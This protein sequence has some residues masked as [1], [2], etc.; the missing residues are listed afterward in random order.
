MKKILKRAICLML[1]AALLCGVCFNGID[2]ISAAASEEESYTIKL[3]KQE[4]KQGVSSTHT[5]ADSQYNNCA[6]TEA[7]I[8]VHE[9]YAYVLSFEVPED[10]T[11]QIGKEAWG[12]SH[13]RFNNTDITGRKAE[14]C[15]T[16]QDG[17][18]LY[19]T[20]GKVVVLDENTT[21]HDITDTVVNVSA[22]D[23]IN[24]V[25]YS[26]SGVKNSFW[27]QPFSEY[28]SASYPNKYVTNWRL[29]PM[30][31]SFNDFTTLYYADDYQ[32]VAKSTPALS[33]KKILFTGDSIG[34]GWRDNDGVD[35]YSNSGGWAKRIADDYGADVTLAAQAGWA[36]STIRE[37]EGRG[38]IVNQLH[39]HKD[40]DFDYIVLEGGFNDAMG[41]NED[42]TKESAAPVGEMTDSFDVN[43]FN[44]AEFA[45]ALE[46]LFYY[47][48][49][50]Y[51]D[52]GI[53]FIITYA[54]PLST[55]GGYTAEV[56]SMR[57]YWNMAKAICNKWDIEYLDLFDGETAAGLSYSYDILKVDT[58]NNF[59]GGTDQIHLNAAGYDVITPYI[60]EWIIENMTGN[61]SEETLKW[62]S[63]LVTLDFEE[64]YLDE[65]D[66][67]YYSDNADNW[68]Y[69][70]GRGSH[71]EMTTG[72]DGNSAVRLTY[73]NQN[74]NENYN[75]NAVMNIYN[76]ETKSR[77]VGTAGTTYTIT[78]DYKVEETDGKELQLF[79][80]PSNRDMGY[81]NNGMHA[82]QQTDMGPGAVVSGKT[83]TFTEATDVITEK[84]DGWVTVSTKYT[85]QAAVNEHEVYP[86]ILLQTNNKTKDTTHTGNRD[87]AA[88]LIDNL[89]VS[90]K[91][92][93]VELDFEK[94]CLN[95][96]ETNYY[97]GGTNESSD[98]TRGS[99]A[100]I[101][102][103]DAGNKAMRL[104]YDNQNNNENYNANAAFN[105]Y[106]SSTKTKFVGTAGK[107]YIITFDYKVECTDD[108]EMQLYVATCG[109]EYLKYS[110]LKSTA[111]QAQD[112]KFIPATG[113]ITQT[114][115][116]YVTTTVSYTANGKDYPIILLST[117]NST[118]DETH[119]G[120][121]AYASVLVDNVKIQGNQ[122]AFITCVNYNGND[123]SL[124]IY[125]D[126]T[127]ADLTTPS[128]KGYIFDGW[129][130][131]ADLM[132]K[133]NE[134]ELVG[135]YKRIYVKWSGDGTAVV[136]NEITKY[137]TTSVGN[138]KSINT[139]TIDASYFDEEITYVQ[140]SLF[141]VAGST[142]VSNFYGSF[143]FS[144]KNVIENNG[145]KIVIKNFNVTNPTAD[146][147]V[148]YV[149]IPDYEKTG[150]DWGLGLGDQ[151]I[152]VSQ[153]GSVIYTNIDGGNN[154]F[155]YSM[156]NEW[157]DSTISANGVFTGLPAGY[158]GYI[159]INLSAL[160]YKNSVD[161]NSSYTFS[162]MELKMNALGGENGD[163]V[164]GGLFYFPNTISDSTV[165][166]IGGLYYELS[167][168]DNGI[169]VDS[170]D[171]YS[172]TG[173]SF[174]T[175]YT[176]TT[177]EPNVKHV[178]AETSA[179]WGTA[180]VG[181][182]TKSGNAETTTGY[183][184]TYINSETAIL[185]QPGV[186]SIMFYVEM[187]KYTAS[188]ANPGLKLLDFTLEQGNV[189]Q[190][191]NFFNSVY[192]Y[193]SVNDASWKV[194][195][196]GADGELYDIPSGFKGYI[197]VDVKQFKNVPEIKGEV[198]FSKP[199]YITKFELGFNHI[200]GENGNL[201]IGGVYSVIK[202][203]DVPFLKHGINGE[204]Y[205][206][207][208]IPGDFNCDGTYDAK[209]IGQIRNHLV[210]IDNSLAAPAK[211]RN[212]DVCVTTLVRA[213]KVDAGIAKTDISVGFSSV[214]NSDNIFTPNITSNNTPTVYRIE[215]VQEYSKKIEA[216]TE[217]N[218]D[219]K[220]IAFAKE[221][222]ENKV[223]DF[224]KTGID[225]MCHVS[226]FAYAKGNIYMSYYANAISAYEHPDYQVARLAYAPEDDTSKK[227][228]LD[229]MQVGDDICGR[230]VTG[231]YDTVLMQRED[232]PDNLYILWTARIN[233][234]YY[235]LYRIFNMET[236][237]LGKINVN[238]F[239]VGD[240]TND[241]SASGMQEAMEANNVGYKHFIEDI[242]IMQKLSTRVEN[243]KT[244][245]YA[246][247]YSG[248]FT[249]IIKST[250]LITWEYVAQPNEGANNTGFANATL[251]ENAVY[252]LDD[253]VYYFVRQ[254]DPNRMT[255]WGY[256][257]GYGYDKD[258]GSLYGI[259]TYYDLNTGE[260]AQPVL[261]GD[262]Q[263]RSDFIYY[264]G[265]LYLF[266]APTD[267]AHIGILKIDT[268]E[269]SKTEV[270]LQAQMLESCFYPFVQYNSTGELCM[271][272]T[273]DRQHIRLASFK[274]S[275]YLD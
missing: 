175:R 31:A 235:R 60:A 178:D 148:F 239:K 168:V 149:E 133:A 13:I 189:E 165:M 52:A 18:I 102:T 215:E 173:S 91:T 93:P 45:G 100:E 197:K 104:T 261:V 136:P 244:Y 56:E 126:T 144:S 205:C 61:V 160:N 143:V 79:I 16:N 51:P 2:I 203:S 39:S 194:A 131:D 9:G 81:P 12:S 140:N 270:V 250:D 230:K 246:G 112:V 225:K 130:T 23:T 21:Q 57:E 89:I 211:L 10:G 86:I 212:M 170:Y 40:T 251:W 222:A 190:T 183:M 74:S 254:W 3:T 48:K 146:A 128:R 167:K 152:G 125:R 187:P 76:P 238:R 119:D 151:G 50:Y 7:E 163:V 96:D 108:K 85:A 164:L 233:G 142:S 103:E 227:V 236:E 171:V 59:P 110:D 53:G 207:K 242:G 255:D 46:N 262:C 36:I 176:G 134:D 87:Y 199:Y 245:Y 156:N 38:S 77:F 129:Y 92:D 127:F 223:G 200:G 44:T 70:N 97:S 1:S 114:T 115:D 98:T 169:V 273:V 141:D 139:V 17:E 88:V 185:M 84:T 224:E 42:R 184:T 267:R 63:A 64:T 15:V 247:A 154:P 174:S 71:A 121:R 274:L 196:A 75:A 214:I 138:V 150:A 228:I 26:E 201:V 195:R 147:V 275:E 82:F 101:I 62:F 209:E 186:D 220:A 263:S 202:D 6:A 95:A 155:E 20:D 19:P 162:A 253:K 234:E 111:M 204:R 122:Q 83:S 188:S 145:E 219:P 47:A 172:E 158:K 198:D 55:Y 78:F 135:N 191:L 99:H 157:V 257:V 49:Q 117:N 107:K 252:V 192:K 260:W 132:I 226:T 33:G 43:D 68:S 66:A 266:Y 94:D 240:V 237:E 137:F 8:V 271:S 11:Y 265:N 272:Y 210:G 268:E 32:K 221:I 241:F 264:Q 27:A 166:H 193:A 181:I 216:D 58:E 22:G 113:V 72:V 105:V 118:K 208:V 65:N 256:T 123:R 243:G 109:R 35:D 159:R 120:T 14:F 232:E 231:V 24:Y 206:F 161:F 258:Y 217:L 5:Y 153:N 90:V 25:L 69:G 4:L 179:F 218:N 54:T 248:N 106:N 177:A 41:T 73:D 269:L 34:A 249:C 67:T 259:L 30:D 182:T 37:A 29:Y 116:G 80:A 229:I 180:P 124:L 213:K 28:T